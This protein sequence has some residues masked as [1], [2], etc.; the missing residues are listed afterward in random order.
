MA[1]IREKSVAVR[2]MVEIAFDIP[3][4]EV[5]PDQSVKELI[6]ASADAGLRE[7]MDYFQPTIVGI[8]L[9]KERQDL[10]AA[11]RIRR[12]QF[13]EKRAEVHHRLMQENN[14]HVP[15]EL[16]QLP[17]HMMRRIRPENVALDVAAALAD[18]PIRELKNVIE[19]P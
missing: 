15:F 16:N 18:E 9:L 12:H 8:E 14:G 1:R 10:I 13:Y 5:N 7:Y 6:A 2:V 3:D 4:P 19:A 17:Q 11:L